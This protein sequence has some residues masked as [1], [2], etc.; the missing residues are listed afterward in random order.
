MVVLLFSTFQCLE[1]ILGFEV[2]FHGGAGGPL[3]DDGVI[4]P[5]N[6]RNVQGAILW[7]A[8]DANLN[9]PIITT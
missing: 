6:I 2:K 4:V 9:L 5:Q 8:K 7:Q 3:K 1:H